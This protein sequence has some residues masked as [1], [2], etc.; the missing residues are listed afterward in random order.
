M[1]DDPEAMS[2]TEAQA[3]ELERRLEAYKLDGEPG[4]PA[5]IGPR[6]EAI[7]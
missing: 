1:A 4:R 6:D 3:E 7:S 5:L 2:L